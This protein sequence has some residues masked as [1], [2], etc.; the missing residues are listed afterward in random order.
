MKTI[1][2]GSVGH[3]GNVNNIDMTYTYFQVSRYGNQLSIVGA[4]VGN[5]AWAFVIVI[6]C[7]ATSYLERE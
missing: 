3:Y 5:S 7:F 1:I 4:C 6:W 2:A